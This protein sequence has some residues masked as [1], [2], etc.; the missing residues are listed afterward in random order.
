MM[1]NA[2]SGKYISYQLLLY[3]Q[4][5]VKVEVGRLG[6][7]T[8]PAGSYLYTGSARNNMEARLTRHLRKEKKLYWH[9]DY[10]TGRTDVTILDVKKYTEEECLVN[11]KTN[12]EIL[13]PGFG[14]SDCRMKC[15]SHLKYL[16]ARR[17]ARIKV[18]Y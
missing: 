5:T 6:K 4:N 12:G 10:L 13:I 7:F 16:E 8:L 9:I 1:K 3:L 11:L 2:T 14:A 17:I 15:G 18:H